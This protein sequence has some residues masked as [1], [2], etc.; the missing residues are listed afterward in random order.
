MGKRYRKFEIGFKRQVVEEIESGLLVTAEAARKYGISQGVVDRWKAKYR[1][2]AL[3]EK[4]S[5][6]E[7]AL[8]AE[9][10]RLKAK[11]GELTMLVDLLK[12]MEDYARQRRSENSSVVT[13]QTL[14]A[15]R[16]GAK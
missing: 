7:K 15:L 5:T 14:A 13:G 11:V 16:G 8:R 2:G 3:I 9:N 12:K 6:E 4:T 10:E 1:A